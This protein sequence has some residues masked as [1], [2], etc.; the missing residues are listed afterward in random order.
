MKARLQ[1]VINRPP[2]MRLLV[3]LRFVPERVI[4]RRR[5]FRVIIAHHIRHR[6][7]DALLLVVQHQNRPAIGAQANFQRPIGVVCIK[8]HPLHL[9]GMI[10]LHIT[11][12]E[13]RHMRV[14]LLGDRF[15]D[16]AVAF[17][18]VNRLGSGRNMHM[19]AAAGV[20]RGHNSLP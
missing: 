10:G 15:A 8:R 17:V 2:V 3:A 6:H 5:E 9:F 13:K 7:A 20:F 11:M 18:V 16:V 19:R 14:L 12:L 4:A 1:P